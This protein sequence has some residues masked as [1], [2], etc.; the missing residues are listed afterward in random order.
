M[1]SLDTDTLLLHRIAVADRH[2][3]VLGGLTVDGDAERR[4]DGILPTITLADRILLVVNDVEIVFEFVDDFLRDFGHAVLLDERQDGRL[5]GSQCRGQAQHHTRIA[6]VELLLGIGRRHDLQEH[7]VDADRRLDD[8][9]HVAFAR[10]GVE[11][12]DFL[13]RE[14]LV[15]AQVE[16]GTRMD[17]LDL[18]EA[19][20]EIVLDVG[21]G[22][23]VVGQLVVIVGAKFTRVLSPK[24]W[25]TRPS[26]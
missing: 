4:T 16:I 19:E 1:Q 21:S 6:A 12:L 5:D 23:G 15:V 13:A 3:A 24:L 9:G 22:V 10:L 26:R 8:I 17:A 11:V 25:G 18:L 20:R 2:G 7:A 14:L